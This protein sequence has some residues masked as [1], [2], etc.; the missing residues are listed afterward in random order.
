MVS[1]GRKGQA[2][3]DEVTEAD[4]PV[5]A[6]AP[7]ATPIAAPT[8][9]FP[10]VNL[11][12][13]EIA[14]EAKVR[15]SKLV[16]G[17]AVAASIAAVAGLY[18]MASADV[19]S[20]QEQLDSARA[21][22]ATLASEQ[23]KYADVPRVQSDLQ[24]A[25]IQQF[26]AMGGEVRWSTVLNNLALTIPPGVSLTSF[27]ATITG[28]SG[29]PAASAAPTANSSV[30]SI[31]G[32]P[33][34]GTVAYDGEARDAYRVAAFLESLTKSNGLLDPFATQVTNGISSGTT[35]IGSAPSGTGTS[36]KVSFTGSVTIGPKALS[37]RYD[38]KGN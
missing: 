35:N 13:A 28:S 38:V 23:S 25:Q 6:P 8:A 4:A 18:V 10:R 9:A 32:V 21:T 2:A 22:S 16:L 14:L 26:A 37:H 29:T 11:I 15:R 34:V 27:Q 24:S 20:A 3:V 36:G 19:S 5:A 30:T 17:A 1:F 31:L 12:P 33:G 7:V